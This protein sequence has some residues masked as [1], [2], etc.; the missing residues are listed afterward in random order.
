MIYS[1]QESVHRNNIT[2]LVKEVEFQGGQQTNNMEKI[3]E[4]KKEF[5]TLFE[6]LNLKYISEAKKDPEKEAKF[7][8]SKYSLVSDYI[9]KTKIVT[10]KDVLG[11]I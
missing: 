7:L 3:K 8:Y 10:N 9:D 5:T 2:Y 4:A 11:Y 1:Y 6:A